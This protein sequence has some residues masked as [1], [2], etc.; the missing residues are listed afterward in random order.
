MATVAGLSK[1]MV[2]IV[3]TLTAVRF[4][5]DGW[6][7]EE[8]IDG[9]CPGCRGPVHTFGKT[10]ASGRRE[11]RYAALVCA[12]CVPGFTLVN[13]SRARLISATQGPT[14]N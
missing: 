7:Y 11:Y 2:G 9:K 3:P 12:T 4:D 6:T 10:Y 5:E 8:A 13:G 14:K 1:E